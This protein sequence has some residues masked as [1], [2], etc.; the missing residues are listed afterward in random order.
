MFAIVTA[1]LTLGVSRP[2]PASG[3]P[4]RSHFGDFMDSLGRAGAQWVNGSRL[5][6]W[7]HRLQNSMGNHN[8][9]K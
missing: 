1:Q 3:D 7:A 4:G 8:P 9:L 6:D 2:E 5:L